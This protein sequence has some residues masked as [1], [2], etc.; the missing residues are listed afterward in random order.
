MNL[1]NRLNKTHRDAIVRKRKYY[2]NIVDEIIEVL[3]KEKFYVNLTYNHVLF[4]TEYTGT[5]IKYFGLLFADE[6]KPCKG[7]G[8]ITDNENESLLGI[9]FYCNGEGTI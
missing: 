1:W 5:D 8:I 2:P 4:I 6:C 7:E 9:C 3:K